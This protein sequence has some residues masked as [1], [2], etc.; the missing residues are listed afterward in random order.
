MPIMIFSAVDFF[1]GH[2]LGA[3]GLWQIILHMPNLGRPINL[4]KNPK[5]F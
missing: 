2:T 1:S 4:I 3:I 5:R